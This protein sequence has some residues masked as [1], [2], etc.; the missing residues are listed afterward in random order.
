MAVRTIRTRVCDIRDCAE[1]AER[2]ELSRAGN[3]Y[4]LD[5]CARHQE[6]V[7]GLPWQKLPGRASTP[8][9]RASARMARGLEPRIRWPNG[10]DLDG[11]GRGSPDRP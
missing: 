11:A 2:L 6:S 8:A 7:T 5:L 3:S 9:E 10:F 1:S 4:A